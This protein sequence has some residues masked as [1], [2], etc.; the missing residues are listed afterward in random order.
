L[1][2][3]LFRYYVSR[4]LIILIIFFSLCSI[5]TLAGVIKAGAL[6]GRLSVVSWKSLRDKNIVKQN[7]DFSCGAASVAT[8]VTYHFNLPKSEKEILKLIGKKNASSFMDLKLVLKKL[9]IKAFGFAANLE[10]LK[11]L[12][13]PAILY[14]EH[15]GQEHFSVFK[16]INR[17]F[18]WLADPSWGN[19]RIVHSRFMNMWKTRN[20]PIFYG[21][22]L[23]VVPRTKKDS[24][25]DFGLIIDSN[26]AYENILKYRFQ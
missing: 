10:M 19:K 15:N 21:K 16:G 17:R 2:I 4:P 13:M 3:L 26:L 6:T 11:K 24:K 7:F 12:K 8:I 20:D 22:M 1:R 14:L 23:V 18:V 25:K 9:K 5:D